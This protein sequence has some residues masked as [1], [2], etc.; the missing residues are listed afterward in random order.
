MSLQQAASLI[1]TVAIFFLNGGFF[2]LLVFLCVFAG[3]CACGSRDRFQRVLASRAC[4]RVRTGL[5]KCK[6]ALSFCFARRRLPHPHLSGMGFF[7]CTIDESTGD[8]LIFLRGWEFF[9]LNNR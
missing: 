7:F 5:A 9:V 1:T 3:D 2:F 4:V 6:S 8:V